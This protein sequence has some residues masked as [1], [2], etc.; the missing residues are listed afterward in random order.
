[1]PLAL[2]EVVAKLTIGWKDEGNG[3][4]KTWVGDKIRL[5]V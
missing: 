5:E 2:I 4:K 1:M 3:Y